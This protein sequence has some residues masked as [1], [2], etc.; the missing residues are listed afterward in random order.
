VSSITLSVSEGSGSKI[1]WTPS[2]GLSSTSTFTVTA[3][4]STSTTYTA[5]VTNTNS[6][7]ASRKKTI[8]VN[9]QFDFSRFPLND[10]S[11]YLGEKIQLIVSTSAVNVNYKWSP[12]DNISCLTCNN[13]W[14]NPTQSI[15]YT[16][17]AENGCINEVVKFNIEV[18]ADFYLE[19]PSAFTP[20][21]DS[22][23]DLFRF[24]ERNIA[25]F[26]LKIFNVT[27]HGYAFEKK[28][29]FLLLK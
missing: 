13:P 3:K 26:E 4:P 9:Q 2:T 11:I 10:T 19:A 12:D 25:N 7:S 8:L 22:N 27:I 18:I 20:N 15:T 5:V 16:V 17:E 14:V 28:G 1:K 21:G 23:N 29:E 24:E 6:C